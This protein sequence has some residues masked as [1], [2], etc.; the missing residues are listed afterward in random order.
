MTKKK[1]DDA[2]QL[3]KASV[4]AIDDKKGIDIICYKLQ[5]LP[6]AVSEYFVIA[7]GSTERQVNAISD[8]VV[9]HVRLKLKE[10]TSHIE[11]K[12]NLEWVLIDYF[13]VVVHIFKPEAREFYNLDGLWADAEVVKFE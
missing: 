1:I 5:G 10:K 9:D 12:E 8:A 11:G 4:E 7:T 6:H 3:A 2:L 13:N